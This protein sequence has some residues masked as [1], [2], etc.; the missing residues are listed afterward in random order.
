MNIPSTLYSRIN[1]L[2]TKIPC[3][4]SHTVLFNLKK[5]CSTNSTSEEIIIPKKIS[6]GPT[7]ILRALEST[8]GRDPT[9]AHYKFH[10]D[11]Y[12]IPQSNIGKRTFAMAQEAGKKAAHF[13]RRENIDLFQHKEAEPFIDMFGPPKIYTENSEV[14]IDDLK[15]CIKNVDVSDAIM[16]YNLL[17]KQNVDIEPDLMQNLLEL[18]CYHNSQDPLPEELIEERW[19]RQSTK[20]NER[21][22]KTWKDGDFAEEIFISIKEPKAETYSAIIQGM[23]KYYQIERA[24]QLFEEA[25]QKGFILSTDTYNAM[26]EAGNL[27]KEN[28][29]MRWAYIVQLLSEMHEKKIK[30]NLGT[31]NAVLYCLSLMGIKFSRESALKV[32]SEFK[33][34][35]I[36]PSLASWNFI[37]QIFYKDNAP[38]SSIMF[39]IMR[40]IENK[41]LEIRDLRDINFFVAAMSICRFH[42]NDLDLAH[43]VD[44]LLHYGNNYDLIGN[45]Y[46]EA[47]YY[48]HYFMLGV[49]SQ[50]IQDF[51]TNMYDKLVPHIYTPE[52]SVLEEILKQIEIY[53]AVEYI[54]KMWS[55]MVIFDSTRKES[56]LN[57]ILNIMVA[58]ERKNDPDLTEKFANVAEDIHEK[59]INQNENS[60]NKIIITGEMIGSMILLFLRNNSFNKAWDLFVDLDK[61]HQKAVG[62][63]RSE[64]IFALVDACI[65]EKLPSKALLILQ[66]ISDY[67]YEGI[68]DVAKNL[69]LK[70]TLDETH[71]EKLAKIVGQHAIIDK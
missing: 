29:D 36:E 60:T 40:E 3:R 6:R 67:G 4:I 26:I 56:M 27:L 65:A 55:D 14:S 34:L 21:R 63:P 66:Y 1:R 58:N 57:L 13:V 8:I 25:K 17:K 15:D 69:Q 18:L 10:D 22:K 39:D 31:L 24:T 46:K 2:Q 61:N 49:N 51:M 11:P 44:A 9:A 71:L 43:R 50:P 19:F 41:Q 64:A 28:Y 32:L 59:L 48:R 12:L 35:G 20:G 52:M 16:V 54:P 68:E 38:L 33:N 23:A 37:L 47:V 30:P 53:G 70:L 42:L 7:D 62:T 45:S 5:N